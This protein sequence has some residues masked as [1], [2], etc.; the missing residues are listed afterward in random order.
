MAVIDNGEV[1]FY[2]FKKAHELLEVNNEKSVFGIGSITKVLSATVL[3]NAIVNDSLDPQTPIREFYDFALKQEINDHLINLANH[4]SGFLSRD[5][6]FDANIDSLRNY[7]RGFDENRIEQTL[8][9]LS[10]YRDET[11]NKYSYS[12]YGFGLLG[13]VLAR[14]YST[15]FEELL[16]LRVFEKYQM[17]KSFTSIQDVD[18]NLV[19][20]LDKN[21]D[22]TPSWD[23]GSLIAA[24]GVFST[25][26]DLSKYVLAHFN[27][28]NQELNLMRQ[29][30]LK[31]DSSME[32]GLGI[33]IVKGVN[34]STVYWHNG[35]GGGYKSAMEFDI[36]TKS[37]VIILSNV[38]FFNPNHWDIDRICTS[39]MNELIKS[40]LG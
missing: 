13:N 16:R 19:V 28:D 10:L 38:S 22:E 35:G 1:N 20:G 34:N 36:E 23:M 3:A 21:G 9:N 30:T 8:K 31:V 32:V 5:S 27:K 14:H 6:N 39:L 15:R 2:G 40:N 33:H 4:S 24:G 18:C 26:D 12:N 7:Y 17:D 37:G 25:V 29:P 11:Y